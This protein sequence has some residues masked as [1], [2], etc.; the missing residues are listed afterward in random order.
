MHPRV[1]PRRDGMNKT[2]AAYAAYLEQLRI[3]GDVRE[4]AFE[5]ENLR[6]ADRTYYRPDFR[7]V[8]EEGYVEFHEVKGFWRDDALVKIKV[9]A[10][11]H[12][13]RFIAVTLKKGAWLEREF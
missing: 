5:P 7:V 6:L 1:H 3:I 9:A 10:K 13:Y 12:P 11:L 8:T 2:E 4:W